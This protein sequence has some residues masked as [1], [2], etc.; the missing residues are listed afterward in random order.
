MKVKHV[1]SEVRMEIDLLIYDLNV[2]IEID[3]PAHWDEKFR[4]KE[5]LQQQKRRDQAKNAA[6]L[7]AGLSLIRVMANGES[8]FNCTQLLDRLDK[9]L[10]KI[11]KKGPLKGI[12]TIRMK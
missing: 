3:G 11:Q 8:E 6:V 1:A 9:E 2:A 4:G 7:N 5:R 12:K 10:K